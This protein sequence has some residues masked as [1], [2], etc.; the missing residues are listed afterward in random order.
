MA[1]TP[2]TRPRRVGRASIL[3][4]DGANGLDMVMSAVAG[5]RQMENEA[6]GDGADDGLGGGVDGTTVL[7]FI[8]VQ[9]PIVSDFPNFY[10]PFSSQSA[11]LDDPSAVSDRASWIWLNDDMSL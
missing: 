6:G 4:K 8:T 10:M 2:A 11:W 5:H 9:D 3:R 7:I 1:E